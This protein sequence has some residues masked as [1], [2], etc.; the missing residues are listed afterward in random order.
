MPGFWRWAMRRAWILVVVLAACVGS[1]ANPYKRQ[2]QF[3]EAEYAPYGKP[4]TS[5]ISGQ[6]FVKT[7]GGDVR[8][9]AGNE[10]GLNPVTTYSNEWFEQTVRKQRVMEAADPRCD[11]YYWETRADG[12]G[13]FTFEN[14][15]AGEYYVFCVISWEVAGQYGMETTGGVASAKV[16]V[17]SGQHL[18]NVI[19]TR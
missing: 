16:K 7:R 13:R 15:P 10:V 14:L 18:K 5:T 1:P 6:A 4:G 11:K 19:V 12:E 3:I 2:A 8:Y 17:G 9:G